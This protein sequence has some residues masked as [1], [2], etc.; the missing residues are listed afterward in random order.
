MSN[1]FFIDS[2]FLSP[3]ALKRKHELENDPSSRRDIMEYLP[4]MEVIQSDIRDQVMSRVA[5]YDASR[6]TGRDVVRAP[7]RR[8]RRNASCEGSGRDARL[9]CVGRDG[10]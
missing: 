10:D 2:E 3:E 4:G 9:Q 8:D 5:E 1:Q 6:Y 7:R